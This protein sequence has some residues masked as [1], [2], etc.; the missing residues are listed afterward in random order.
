ML[1]L[2]NEEESCYFLSLI[3]SFTGYGIYYYR[4]VY[5]FFMLDDN[6]Y[7]LDFV[8]NKLDLLVDESLVI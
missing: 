6:G 3:E 8:S 4:Y 5:Y 1:V 7:F 2:S